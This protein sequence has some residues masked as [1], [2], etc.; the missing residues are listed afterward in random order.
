[1]S[2]WSGPN[3][4]RRRLLGAGLSA[5]GLIGVGAWRLFDDGPPTEP[6]LAPPASVVTADRLVEEVGERYL[7]E[8]PTEAD[9]SRLADLLPDGFGRQASMTD[10]GPA[11]AER[12]AADFSD[13]SMI[14]L[15]GWLF[16]LTECRAA[17]LLVV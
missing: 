16:S 2:R 6:A 10:F 13:G 14:E 4:S 9:R 8:T 15:D 11:T 12:I 17:A 1:M 7:A 5:A 3:I